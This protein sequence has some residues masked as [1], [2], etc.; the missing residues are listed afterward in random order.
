MP[1]SL[2]FATKLKLCQ[3]QLLL[4]LCFIL[5]DH[6]VVK[7]LAI[8]CIGYH[9]HRRLLPVTKG[10]KKT[11]RNCLTPL[12]LHL[13]PTNA[14]SLSSLCYRCLTQHLSRWLYC[15]PS[16]VACCCLLATQSLAWAVTDST[17]GTT[18]TLQLQQFSHPALP[19]TASDTFL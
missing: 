12:S 9:R 1:R 2:V 10:Q 7:C 3:V 19:T 11:R 13:S 6:A 15:C 14:W 4:F 16:P 8:N 18:P 5:L 17:K